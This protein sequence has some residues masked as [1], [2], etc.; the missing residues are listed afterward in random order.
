MVVIHCNVNFAMM[1][2]LCDD[3]DNGLG[4]GDKKLAGLSEYVTVYLV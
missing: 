2:F 4:N 1:F 3:D